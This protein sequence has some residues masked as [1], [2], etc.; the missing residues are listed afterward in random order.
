MH[1]LVA[2]KEE[3][4]RKALKRLI[5]QDP[6]LRVIG[7]A[8]EAQSL[9]LLVQAVRP[10]LVLVHCGL[11]G[12]QPTHLRAVMRRLGK[13]VKCV[14]FGEHA[15]G[16]CQALAAGADAFVSKREPAESLLNAVRTVGGLSP[17]YV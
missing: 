14:V 8:A 11:P 16:Y 9:L 5:E 3:R 4:Q 13:T 17:C 7:E 10:E 15:D 1:I 6:A 2:H 12:F